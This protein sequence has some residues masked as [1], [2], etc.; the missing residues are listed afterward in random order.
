[1][2]KL[3][4][5]I[6]IG[7]VFNAAPRD[8]KKYK[9]FEPLQRE[10]II[11]IDL[12]DYDFLEVDVKKLETCDRC[13]PVM[14]LAMRVLQRALQDDFGF[15]QQL[16]V[17]SGRRG[18]HCWACDTRGRTMSNEVRSAVADYLGP[19][20]NAASGRMVITNPMHPSLKRAYEEELIPFF[21]NTMLL[22]EADGGFG[23]L[24]TAARQEK[25]LALFQDESV[26]ER[27]LDEWAGKPRQSGEDRWA[28]LQKFARHSKDRAARLSSILT[29]IVFT[30]TYPRLDVNVS[31]GM[32][33]LLKSPW[34][35]HPKTGRV[36][37]PVAVDESESFDPSAVPTLQSLA[38]DLD[39]SA[40]VKEG[41]DI[42][43]TGLAQYE[44]AFDAFL[45]KMENAIR[46]ERLREKQAQQ[47]QGIVGA[48]AMEF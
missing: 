31:K 7:A 19:R 45:K 35:V 15:E 18:I 33:H 39:A 5:K 41:S 16:W 26:K 21:S 36:C 4:H 34:C 13:W 9:L 44:A 38:S 3:P 8:H 28:S 43:R 37:V 24:D 29:E 46:G 30:Y 12:T 27:F 6:D 11:D 47:A 10:F 42:S 25:L 14:A 23:I 20:I 48:T 17:Y 40:G 1:V 32:N 22:S 2:H